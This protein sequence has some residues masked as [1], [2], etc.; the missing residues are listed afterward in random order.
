MFT[1]HYSQAVALYSQSSCYNVGYY[2][3]WNSTSAF[4]QQL[5]CSNSA[6]VAKRRRGGTADHFQKLQG[7]G[8]ILMLLEIK[9]PA[10]SFKIHTTH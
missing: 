10:P 4:E 5:R 6:H 1:E 7:W 3:R 9:V 8:L 2:A